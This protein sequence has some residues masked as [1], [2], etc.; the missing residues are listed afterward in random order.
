MGNCTLRLQQCIAREGAHLDDLIFK[1]WF[2]MCIPVC[3]DSVLLHQ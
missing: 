3:I 2:E 1:K